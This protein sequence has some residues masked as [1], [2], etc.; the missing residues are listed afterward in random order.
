[1]YVFK[2][3]NVRTI[4]SGHVPRVKEIHRFIHGNESVVVRIVDQKLREIELWR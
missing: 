2:G 3:I 4:R 1:M